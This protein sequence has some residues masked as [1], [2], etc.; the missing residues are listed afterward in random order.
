M[1]GFNLIT[2]VCGLL[3]ITAF[4]QDKQPESKALELPRIQVVPI[5]DTVNDRQYDLFIKLPEGYSDTTRHP[6]IYY[7][8]AVWHVEMLSGA[9]EYIMEDVILVGISWQTDLDEALMQEVGPQVSRYRDYSMK[10]SSNQE[11]QAKYQFG[12]ADKHLAFIRNDVIP[13][14]ENNYRT[15]PEN[16][17]YF[18]YS[19]GGEFGIYILLSQPDTF[20]N[21]I[22]GSPSLRGDDIP[23]LAALNAKAT[24][25]LNANVFI[26]YGSQEE[27]LGALA[28]QL[29][30]LLRSR[31]DQSLNLNPVVIE[32]S[33]QTAFPLTAVRSV[34]WLSDLAKD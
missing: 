23:D 19:M 20:N 18:G 29:I 30:S 34:T 25:N 28:E 10:E 4:A 1:K 12:Q 26:S 22:L 5:T 6:V 7:T 31:T 24:N 2:L 33:H 9:A 8:D 16:R 32:G 13:Y 14:M 11:H 17:T 15:N 27:R 21:Y 3:V